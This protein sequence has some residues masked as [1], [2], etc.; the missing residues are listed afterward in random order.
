MQ[1]L[2]EEF[3]RGLETFLAECGYRNIHRNIQ[4]APDIH[5]KLINVQFLR[6]NHILS[7][8]HDKPIMR[9]LSNQTIDKL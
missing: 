4:C 1:K 8:C 2:G 7:P 6:E 3:N 9:F 5:D